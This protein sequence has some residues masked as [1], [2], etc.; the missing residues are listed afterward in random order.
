MSP[1]DMN[2]P[3]IGHFTERK[4]MY[5]MRVRWW[6]FIPLFKAANYLSKGT[7][8]LKLAVLWYA[9]SQISGVLDVCTVLLQ[10]FQLIV[11]MNFMHWMR[12]LFSCRVN[13]YGFY[14]LLFHDFYQII[15]SQI[16][17]NILPQVWF[18]LNRIQLLGNMVDG[19]LILA[20]LLIWIQ[21]GPRTISS[22][23]TVMP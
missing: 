5:G 11:F 3:W 21:F 8:P 17:E 1:L 19:C 4:V 23:Q 16:D 12:Q 22:L 13:L 15:F 6:A 7:F 20:T 18:C 9:P 14:T 2:V 10:V